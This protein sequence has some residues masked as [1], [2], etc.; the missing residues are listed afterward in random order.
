MDPLWCSKDGLPLIRYW[1]PAITLERDWLLF[2]M[3]RWKLPGREKV[4]DQDRTFFL[5]PGT[6]DEFF[7]KYETWHPSRG[8]GSSRLN[9]RSRISPTILL[10]YESTNGGIDLPDGLRREQNHAN[11]NIITEYSELRICFPKDRLPLGCALCADLN[12]HVIN[13]SRD[14]IFKAEVYP[15]C[16]YSTRRD[17]SPGDACRAGPESIDRHPNTGDTIRYQQTLRVPEGPQIFVWGVL[18]HT[19]RYGVDYKVYELDQNGTRGA[20]LYDAQCADGIP[21]CFSPYFDY[22]HIPTRF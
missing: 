10:S 18:G 13:Y 7:Q 21:G 12:A 20:L 4:S 14:K 19:H 2:Q 17:S 9:S 16:L 22:Q 8:G 1:Y 6:E 15:Q 3:G 5:A 11:V